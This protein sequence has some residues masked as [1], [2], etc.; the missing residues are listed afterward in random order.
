MINHSLKLFFILPIILELPVS[1]NYLLIKLPITC[2]V[3]HLTIMLQLHNNDTLSQNL[4]SYLLIIFGF[5]LSCRSAEQAGLCFQIIAHL[6]K[7]AFSETLSGPL[8]TQVPLGHYISVRCRKYHKDNQLS[9]TN[10]QTSR[11][12]VVESTFLK[13]L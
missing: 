3:T 4:V 2:H 9:S 12:A 11:K 8:S 6:T 1:F 10:I 7:Y 13:W 5:I